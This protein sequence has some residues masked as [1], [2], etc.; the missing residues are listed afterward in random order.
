LIEKHCA[1]LFRQARFANNLFYNNWINGYAMKKMK[2][3]A[4]WCKYFLDLLSGEINYIGYF[5][6]VLRDRSVYPSL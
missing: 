4:K 1:N 6:E 2:G 3:N 5:R